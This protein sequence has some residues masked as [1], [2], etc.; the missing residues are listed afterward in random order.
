M[1]FQHFNMQ[2]K[3]V[4]NSGKAKKKVSLTLLQRYALDPL[5]SIHI[6]SKD[7]HRL[8]LIKNTLYTKG[9]DGFST[10]S[11]T[12]NIYTINSIIISF[13]LAYASEIYVGCHGASRKGQL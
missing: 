4:E 13:C 8:V 9:S 11:H 10:L 1:G 2:V 7:H 6:L 3:N 5:A 12:P